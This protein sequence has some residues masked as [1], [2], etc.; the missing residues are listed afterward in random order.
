[1]GEALYR[2]E[3]VFSREVMDRCDR[4]IRQERGV[5]LLD[6]MFGRAGA[7]GDLD[8]P[9]WTQPAIYALECALTALWRSV[10]I[11]PVA[12]LGHSLGEIA[13]AWAA[14]V[15]TLEQGMKFASARGRLMGDLPGA[16]AMAAVFAP[17]ARVTEAVEN[18]RKEHPGSD[19]LHRRGQ[20]R[21]P[22]CQRAGRKR[23]TPWPTGWSPR[24]ST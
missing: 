15:F 18:W 8:E 7:E 19:S 23:Y 10:G 3:P 22:G 20:R 1:M 4:F 24:A 14:G 17:V 6:V 9:R 13:A 2:Q 5:S 21:A 12:V 16:G 11:E